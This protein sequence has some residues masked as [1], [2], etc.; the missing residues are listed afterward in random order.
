MYQHEYARQ[1]GTN[2]DQSLVGSSSNTSAQI[3]SLRL[4]SLSTL[5]IRQLACLFSLSLSLSLSLSRC[6]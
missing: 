2:D 3:N 4:A 6:I 1:R 5:V